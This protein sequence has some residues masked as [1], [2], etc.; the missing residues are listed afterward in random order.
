MNLRTNV[1]HSSEPRPVASSFGKRFSLGARQ[2]LNS[3]YV[4]GALIVAGVIGLLV[5]SGTVFI[6]VALVVLATSLYS[7]DI[8]LNGDQPRHGRKKP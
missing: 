7:G 8:R 3:A 5:Q 6:V 4:H 2:K 1:T